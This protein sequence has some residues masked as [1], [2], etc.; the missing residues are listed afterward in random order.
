MNT[1]PSPASLS[2]YNHDANGDLLSTGPIYP[3]ALPTGY[4]MG[5]R[6]ISGP[7]LPSPRLVPLPGKTVHDGRSPI[8]RFG[9]R[10]IE[11][12]DAHILKD[13][14]SLHTAELSSL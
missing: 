13:L 8:Q 11:Q 6:A 7:P 2:L 1:S 5:R 10:T 14:I 12:A 4:F 3:S 9:H